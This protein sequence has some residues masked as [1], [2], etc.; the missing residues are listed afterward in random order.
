MGQGHY[1][2]RQGLEGGSSLFCE[3][4]C[5]ESW[6]NQWIVQN[7]CFHPKMPTILRFSVNLV[8]LASQIDTLATYSDQLY[9]MPGNCPSSM[10]ILGF[11]GTFSNCK[12]STAGSISRVCVCVC[13]CVCVS[14]SCV[15]ACKEQPCL[16]LWNTTHLLSQPLEQW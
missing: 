14:V 3:S 8:V 10:P 4:E 1:S 5:K 2:Q 13:V 12:C 9:Q 6:P 16:I 7:L 15:S 11:H